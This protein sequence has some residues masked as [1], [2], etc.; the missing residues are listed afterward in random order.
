MDSAAA[1]SAAPGAIKIN[2]IILL[3]GILGFFSLMM[4]WAC[5][6]GTAVLVVIAAI[7]GIAG[8]DWVKAL[9]TLVTA[10]VFLS[11]GG[12]ARWIGR[13]F[14]EGRKGRAIVACVLMLAWAA[15]ALRIGLSKEGQMAVMLPSSLA[16]LTFALFTIM[17]FRN[18]EYWA[19]GSR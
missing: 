10:L 19:K 12:V 7:Q 4:F 16:N 8:N 6:I 9:I 11:L 17:S 18:R 1:E 5:M 13:G 3:T 14:L 15:L 2:G